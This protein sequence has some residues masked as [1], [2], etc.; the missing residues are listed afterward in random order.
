MSISLN[1]KNK[2]VKHVIFNYVI[3]Y[4]YSATSNT[5]LFKCNLVP[6]PIAWISFRNRFDE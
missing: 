5:G 3:F 2:I 1:K 6:T 4:N